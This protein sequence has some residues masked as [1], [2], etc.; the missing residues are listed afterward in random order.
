LK[1]LFS[2]LTAALLLV[3]M[4][5]CA[6]QASAAINASPEVKASVVEAAT[7]TVPIAATPVLVSNDNLDS[8]WDEATATKIVLGSA[9]TV[10][11][12]GAA[13]KN[14]AV[15]ITTSGTYVVSGSLENGQ[16][17][18]EAT[19]KDV[20]RLVLNGAQLTNKSGAAIYAPQCD[21]LII[22]LASGTQN[23]LTDGGSGFAYTNT[24]DEE[25]NAALF[26]KDDLTINGTGALTVNAGFNNGI[27]TKDNLVIVSGSFTVNAANHGIR[28]N[29]SIAIL[30]G[31]FNIS[32]GNDGIQTSN[33]EESGTVDIKGGTFKIAS[34]HDGIQS[35]NALLI[36][37]GDF[38]IKA[39]GSTVSSGDTSDSYK[40]LKAAGNIEITAGTFNIDSADD[41]VHSNSNITIKG[42]AFTLASGD[43][44]V[45]ADSTL[46]ISGGTI[47]VTKSYEGL[48]GSD[49]NISGGNVVVHATDDG[50]NAAGG[51]NG[52]TEG[53]RFGKDQFSTGSAHKML[54]SGGTVTVFSGSDGLDSN[55]TLE[56]S[57]GTVAI[58]IY[59]PRDGDATDTDNGGTIIPALY[60]NIA[61]KSGTK[62]SVGDWSITTQ[63]EATSFCLLLPGLVN[64]QSYKIIANGTALATI[65][66]TSSIQGMMGGGNAG[67][68]GGR[69]GS[70]G[71]RG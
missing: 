55:G 53:G 4:V 16:I 38:T 67:G 33:A 37:G 22:T 63:A 64:G 15:S 45:H 71:R 23:T 43:D 31:N 69:G 25:P 44:G 61:V 3:S 42:G 18:V 10:S 68:M 49:I 1:K 41:A 20:V 12:L 34:V 70:G 36:T 14:N 11:G 32:A 5:G 50:I 17:I 24:T 62:L 54:I 60:G 28:G 40:G 59:A 56:V 47:N 65:T 57:G 27:G 8:S 2:L 52:S 13:V 6:K 21:K 48:E 58:F 9:I 39:G 51:T 29:D 35:E 7:A 19:K 30:D 26:C 66:A 46:A